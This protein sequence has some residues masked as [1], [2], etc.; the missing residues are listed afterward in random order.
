MLKMQSEVVGHLW[1]VQSVDK[2]ICERRHF[3]ISEL[4]WEFQQISCTVLYKII[5]VRP[6]CHKFL[7][8]MGSENAHGYAQ[9]AENGIGFDPLKVIPHRCRWISQSHHNRWLNLGFICECWNQRAVK[10]VD[11]HTFTKQAKTFKQMSP[12]K[13]IAAIFWDRKVVLMVEF[14]Q[15]GATIMSRVYCMQNTKK[16]VQ[17]HSEQKVWNADI[18]CSAPPWQCTSAYISSHLSTA[19]T[20]Q[21][22]VVWP[23][24]LQLWSWSEQL[25]PVYLREELAGSQHFSNNE[26]LTEGVQTWL[27]SQ[28]A[29]FFDTGIQKLIPRYDKCLS[30]STDNLQK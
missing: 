3:T 12:R 19:G 27:S 16:T 29:D 6:G 25:Q 4:S 15:Q 13:L 11:A 18:W 5:T 30:F 28:A 9:I 10:A 21:L 26:E 20:F 2:N 1:W 14:M 23:P 8:K 17:S 22:G 24:S 7:H